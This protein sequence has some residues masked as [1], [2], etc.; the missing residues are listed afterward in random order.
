MRLPSAL[1]TEILPRRLT[2]ISLFT[3]LLW[4]ACLIRVYCATYRFCYLVL[5]MSVFLFYFF[6]TPAVDIFGHKFDC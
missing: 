1:E 5:L 2:V 6:T 4:V 3:V